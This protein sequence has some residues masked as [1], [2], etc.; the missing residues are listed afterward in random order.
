ML[1]EGSTQNNF[2]EQIIQLIKEKKIDE[3][4]GLLVKLKLCDWNCQELNS[5]ITYFKSNRK[6]IEIWS[7]PIYYRTFT[8]TFIQQLVKSYFGN[9]GRC[10]SA[11]IFMKT[12]NTNCFA[13]HAIN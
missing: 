10:F 8:E 11:N 6:S 5:L 3:V 13:I 9:L 4:F 1:N 12:L 2:A 7:N